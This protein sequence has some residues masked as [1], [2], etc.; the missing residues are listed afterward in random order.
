M[1]DLNRFHLNGLRALEVVYRQGTLSKAAEEMGISPGAVSQHVIKAEQQLGFPVFHR[2]ASGLTATPLGDRLLRCLEQGF[3]EIARG[4]EPPTDAERAT[5]HISCTPVHASKWLVARL[6]AFL[7][8]NPGFQVQVISSLDV[9][10]LDR[11]NIDIALRTGKG[12]WSGTKAELLI[13]QRIFPVCSPALAKRLKHP[14][15][16][17]S[18]PIIRNQNALERWGA[19]LSIHGLAEDQLGVGPTFS[20]YSLCIDAATAGLG[21]MLGTQIITRDSVEAGHLAKPFKQDVTTDY[22]LWFVTSIA[23]EK[24]R[25]IL[26]FKRWLQRKIREDFELPN[27]SQVAG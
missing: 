1:A 7:A 20:D 8:K 10:E 5:I 19:W 11:S 18:V 26:L 24:D 12:L 17:L 3:R 4:V 2:T 25:K 21:V 27:D 16:L 6:P 23:H 9:V 15:D 13:E 22:G 14:R